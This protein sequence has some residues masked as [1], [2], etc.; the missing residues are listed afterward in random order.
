MNSTIEQADFAH[1]DPPKLNGK[2]YGIGGSMNST[3]EQADFAH[4]DPQWQD[5]K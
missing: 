2:V 4:F 3:I 5:V 1:F